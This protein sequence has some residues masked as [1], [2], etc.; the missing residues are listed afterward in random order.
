MSAFSPA[1][2][3]TLHFHP[4]VSATTVRQITHKRTERYTVTCGVDCYLSADS[5]RGLTQSQYGD[6]LRPIQPINGQFGG[7]GPFHH[8]YI[9]LTEKKNCRLGF[10]VL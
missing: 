8:G 9:V 4:R 1:C 5:R 7:G 10:A 3:A 2:A 6:V